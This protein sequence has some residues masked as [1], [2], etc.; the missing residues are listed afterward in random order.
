MRTLKFKAHRQSNVRGLLPAS[1]YSRAHGGPQI[2][3]RSSDNQAVLSSSRK[4][5]GAVEHL[6]EGSAEKRNCRSIFE[7]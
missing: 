7:F 5:G 2:V 1:D 6:I 3:V 4:L